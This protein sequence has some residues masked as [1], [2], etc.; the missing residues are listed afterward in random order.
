MDGKEQ[1]IEKFNTSVKGTKPN[2]EKYNKTHDGKKGYAL[3]ELFEIHHNGN[4][5]ADIYGYELKSET[6]AKTSFGDWS[7]N[8][9]IFEMPE[10]KEIF[11]EKYKYQLKNHFLKIFGKPNPNKGGR[12]SWSG[13]ACPKLS[14]Y[15]E[16]GQIMKVEDNNDIVVYYSYSKDKRE[17]KAQI[18]PSC[19]QTEDLILAK[20]YGETS[21]GTRPKDKCLKARV[22]D[23]FNKKGFFTCK[24]NQNGEYDRLCFGKS[25]SFNE[26]I[27]LLKEGIV[28]FDSGMNEEARRFRSEWRA[29]NCFWDSRITEIYN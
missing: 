23:K 14:K 5:E 26:W 13:T 2:T 20:W 22:E 28:Y 27:R 9:Y 25:L 21:L 16:L 29:N 12:L 10:Y 17:N 4:N 6:T 1:L 8:V 11:N 18:V 3:E 24:T 7:A 15:N 19:M